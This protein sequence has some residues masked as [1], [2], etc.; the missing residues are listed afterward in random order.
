M[1]KQHTIF[2]ETMNVKGLKKYKKFKQMEMKLY[3]NRY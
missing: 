3:G 2:L 1:K